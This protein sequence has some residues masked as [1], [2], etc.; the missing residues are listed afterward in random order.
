MR[1]L[2]T[3]ANGQLGQALR[4]LLD[5]GHEVIWTDLPELDV[6]D[7]PSLRSLM[8]GQRPNAVLHLAATTRVD[9]CESAPEATFEINSLGTRYIALAAR[10]VEAQV[11]FIS[12]DYVFDGR[13][14]RAYREYD[15]PVPLNVYGWSKLH[16]E[17]A[18]RELVPQHYVVRTSGLFGIGGANF[19][20]TILRIHE[21][22][23]RLRVVDDQICRPTYARHLAAALVRILDSGNYGIFHIA[24]AQETSW[25]EFARAV[26]RAAGRDPETV[27]PISS[28]EQESPAERPAYSV[29]DTR[30][31][32]M[33]FGEALAHWQEGLEEFLR[34]RET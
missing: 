13:L 6:R 33:M 17:R 8:R 28:R 26:L 12:T 3:G 32:E 30:A 34:L 2:V 7:L 9:D 15:S 22:E 31:Y 23:G 14:G 25:F 10:E 19:V 16:G 18:V 24:S 29:L 4:G 11:L 21:R 27:E 20:R 1:I 5:S